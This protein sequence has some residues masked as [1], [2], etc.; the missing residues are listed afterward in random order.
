MPLGEYCAGGL[1]PSYGNVGMGT[2]EYGFASPSQTPF[3]FEVLSEATNNFSEERLLHEEGQFSAFYKGDLTHLG[4][5]V[6]AAVKWLK[7]KPGQ[8]FAVENYVKEFAT[9]SLAIRHRN[10]VPFLG[11]SSEQ[12]NLCLVYK[13]V[14]N[15]SLHDH[16]YS[17][18]RL[19]TWPTRYKIVFAI[20]SGLKHLHQDVRP[21]FP[22]GNIKP[23]NVLLDEEMNAKL[24][25][26]GLPRHFCQYD[27][28]TASSSYR[29]M[30]VSSRGYVEPGLLHT[31][32]ATTSSDVYS[33]GVVLLEI[34]CGQP[35][36]ILQQDQAEANSLVKL[37]WE[38][39]KKGSIIEA[40]DK[41]LNG[42]FNREQMER[43]LRVGLLCARRG[44]SQRLSM[45]DAMMLLEGVGF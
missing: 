5:S 13:Y 43:V 29:Q 45:G 30:P 18:G 33:F 10:I 7:I 20:G 40:A 26:F 28:E 14:K 31:D 41:R 37:V 16:L 6:A 15:W 24:G 25:D 1:W 9:I 36:I 8:A 2:G 44:S 11:W 23:S 12:D 21:T 22:H 39:H 3:S 38:C 34:A 17:P 19:L 35:P 32:Q 42:E 27:G 4:I